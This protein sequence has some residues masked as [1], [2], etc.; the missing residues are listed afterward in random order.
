MLIYM[1]V[2]NLE[3]AS[4]L[5]FRQSGALAPIQGRF[6]EFSHSTSHSTFDPG[7][8]DTSVGWENYARHSA[9]LAGLRDGESG[10][11]NLWCGKAVNW[12]NWRSM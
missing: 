11:A 3:K 9:L 4:D 10:P 2:P 8:G 12:E 7:G 5:V 1:A 6:H